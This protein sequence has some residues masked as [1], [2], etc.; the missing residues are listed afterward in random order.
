MVVT[1]SSETS[2]NKFPSMPRHIQE[3]FYFHHKDVKIL[4]LQYQPS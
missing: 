2:L 1:C 3:D 4:K